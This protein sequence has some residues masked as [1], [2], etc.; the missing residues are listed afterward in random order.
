MMEDTNGGIFGPEMQ[1]GTSLDTTNDAVIAQLMMEV[2]NKV[3]FYFKRNP[4]VIL[5]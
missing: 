1:R 3:L 2:H 5:Q 4:F